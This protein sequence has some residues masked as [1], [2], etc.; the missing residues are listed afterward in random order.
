MTTLT[1][2]WDGPSRQYVVSATGDA[3]EWYSVDGDEWCDE[4]GRAVTSEPF[5]LAAITLHGGPRDGEVV[6]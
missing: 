3:H 2:F 4:H 6:A 1:A 5:S